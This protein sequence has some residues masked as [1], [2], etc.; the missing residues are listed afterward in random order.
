MKNK[1]SKRFRIIIYIIA[2]LFS[3]LVFRVT[4]LMFFQKELKYS[5]PETSN[6]KERG[7]ILD[8]NGEKLALSLETYSIYARPTEIENKR[9]ASEKLAQALETRYDKILKIIN[10]KRP[11]VWIE[12]QI[13]LKYIDNVKNLDIN[14]IYLEKEYKRYYPYHNLASHI[15]GFSGIDNKGLEGIEYYFDDVLLPRRIDNKGLDYSKYK[16]GYSV[17]LTIDKHIQEIVEEELDSALKQTEAKLITAIV[18]KVNTG[19]ILAL[20]NKPDYDLNNFQKYSDEDVIRNKAITDPFEPGSTFKI[21]IASILMDYGLIHENDTFNC[22]GYINIENHTIHDTGIHGKVNFREVLEKSCNVG[23]IESIK[24]IDKYK[25]YNG[26]REFGFGTLTGINLPGETKGI[27]RNPNKWSGISK[28]GIAI[29]QEISLTSL[30]LITA[31][32]S[33]GNNG[34]LMHPRIVKIIEKPDGTILKSFKTLKVRQTIS[35]QT[36]KRILNI[37]TGVLT[38]RGT[39]YKAKIEG[40]NIAGKTGTAQIADLK[41]GGYLEN[42]FY[43]SFIGFIPVPDPKIVVLVTIDS[44]AHEHYGGQTAAPIFRKIVERVAPYLNILP[45]SSEIY[46]LKNEK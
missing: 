41:K 43:A 28:Y 12:R 25:L 1:L 7:F 46:I 5:A 29:G 22:K 10:K 3:I 23:M 38:E 31:A 9:E 8:R 32:S 11:F 34:V 14:G 15:I 35:Q 20:S 42:Q 33:I 44:P 39:G 18:T 37:L 24:R 4:K 45:S 40:Y 36:S 16:R 27:L 19:E 21:F 2:F 13:D 26:L 6:F 17:V 30:Q